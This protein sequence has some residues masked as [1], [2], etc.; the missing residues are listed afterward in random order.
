MKRGSTL[1]L[2]L[3]I[4]L[5]GIGALAWLLGFPHLEGRNANAD[6][7]TIYFRDPFL[8]YVY[9][10]SIPFF[11]G[12]YQ[13]LKLLNYIDKN[14]TFSDL[15]VKC[16]KYMKYCAFVFSGLLLGAMSYVFQFAHDDDSPGVVVIGFMIILAAAAVGT[17][18]AVFQRLL[19]NA[20]DLKSENDLT[21]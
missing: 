21:V 5:I 16:L 7:F 20:V 18:I 14:Q 10:T 12:L 8:A 17:A 13:A 9:L 2:R 11:V 15:S 19:Q 6:L 3:F 1:F 4:V